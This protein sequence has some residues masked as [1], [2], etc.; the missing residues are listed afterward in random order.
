M[1]ATHIEA[2]L[3]SENDQIK[4]ALST[5]LTLDTHAVVERQEVLDKIIAMVRAHFAVE[6]V[7][8]FPAITATLTD[9]RLA[10]T[11]ISNHQQINKFIE[12]LITIPLTD[13]SHNS[14]IEDFIALTL[15]NTQ[16]E[17]E[18]LFPLLYHS[19]LDIKALE[20]NFNK[21]QNRSK[22]VDG[23]HSV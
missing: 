6:E 20:E 9:Y 23:A 18:T 2:T 5:L 12:E 13:S 11:H 21:Y 19:A 22:E 8:L 15:K 4:N 16:R 14:K 3:K 7:V 1:S 10:E 17:E